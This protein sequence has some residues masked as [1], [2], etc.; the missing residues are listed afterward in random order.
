[1]SIG[2]GC[3]KPELLNGSN[4]ATFLRKDKFRP[5]NER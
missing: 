1:M 5:R 3:I 4:I 2:D